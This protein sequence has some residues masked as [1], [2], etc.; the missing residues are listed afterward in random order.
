MEEPGNGEAQQ[1]E[2]FGEEL[3]EEDVGQG[4]R[5]DDRVQEGEG[6]PGED[7]ADD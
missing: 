5:L 6:L 3:R 4:D 1:H 7:E 2:G